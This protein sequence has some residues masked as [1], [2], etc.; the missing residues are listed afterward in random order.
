MSQ[1]THNQGNFLRRNAKSTIAAVLVL[2]LSF[3]E[4]VVK[5][6]WRTDANS[7]IEQIRKRNAQ[8]TVHDSSGQPISDV[9][10]QIDQIKHRFAFGTCINYNSLSSNATYRNFILNHFEWAVC[11]NEMKW[12][13][14]ESTR[15]Q[16]NYTQADYIANWCANNGLILRGHNIVWETGAQTPSWVSG[17][18]CATYPTDSEMLQEVDERI[19]SV[20][21]RYAG[22]IVQWDVDNEMLSGN[23]YDCLGEAGRAHMFALANSVD[24]NCLMMMN[25]Y[26]G[27]SFG[28][29]DGNTYANRA[30]GLIA[31]GAPVEGLG[32]Q[33]HISSP[34]GDTEAQNYWTKVLKPLGT[35]GLPIMATE[36]DS[37][38]TS[39]SQRATDLENYFRICF[40][41][42]NVYGIM[43]WGFMVGTTWRASGQWGIVSSGG[44]LNA[45]GQRYESLLS[46]WTTEDANTTDSQGNVNFRGFHGT[47]EITLAKAGET[48]EIH[49][50]ELVPDANNTTQQFVIET[51]FTGGPPDTN[52]PTPNPMTWASVPAAM[53]PY[54]ITMTAT[55]ATDPHGVEYYFDCNTAGGHDSGWQSSTTYTDTGLN[56][57]TQYTYQVKARDKSINH[58]ETAWST[59]QSAI[60]YPPDTNAPTPNPMTWASPPAAMGAYSITMTATT[61]TDDYSPPVQY[62]FECTTDSSKSSGWQS[63]ATY[64]ATGLTPN[65]LYSFRVEACDSAPTPNVTGWSSTLSATTQ[66]PPTDVN[67]L[68]SWATGTTH[69]KVSGTNRALIFIAHAEDNGAISLNSVKYGGQPMTKVIDISVSSS[70]Y[71]AYVA[72]YILNE[73]NIAAATSSTFEPNWSTTPDTN[74]YSSVFLQNVN[75]TTLT[76]ASASNGTTSS[77]PITTTALS[78]NSGDM[79]ILGATCG[80]SG[81]YTLNNGFTEANDQTMASTATGVTGYKK[82]PTASSETP[83]A[84]YVG[85]L[86]RQVI[87]G[88]VVKAAAVGYQNC[89][90]VIAAGRRLAADI[91]G[92]GDCYVNFEDLAVF[93]DYWLSTDCNAPDNCHGAD[94][95]PTDSVV[96]LFDFSDF[97]S[98]WMQC[99]DPQDPNC[100]KNW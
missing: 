52:A 85:T 40:S 70:G 58:N 88:F 93:V 11:E 56:A 68:G 9:N 78:T 36:F 26:S 53:G 17:L 2:S 19:N 97:A 95:K 99:N 35:V 42:P 75:Q 16:E 20:V 84:T 14:N 63:S 89:S 37:D 64:T 21:G 41:D 1:Q 69:T 73:A 4:A 92:T 18:Q 8:I 32:I 80:N 33:G 6:D 13:S 44:V 71:Y 39:D 28:G 81:S 98:Q 43:M 34:F 96:D 38:T 79:V 66:S 51:N 27:N 59:Q 49:T 72:A 45:A 55:T 22:Q 90:Q 12:A 61:A 62:Y 24:P 94:F 10:V 31:L 67:I 100:I 91:S 77:N 23:F 82:T 86:N 54:S 87:I 47:Y 60:T 48:N 7:R 15:D 65:T 83:S 57:S 5:G 76:G 25:E 74:A 3:C 29:Y 50:I 46:Q 30:R